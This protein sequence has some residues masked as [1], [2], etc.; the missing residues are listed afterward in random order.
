MISKGR[1]WRGHRLPTSCCTFGWPRGVPRRSVSLCKTRGGLC[2]GSEASLRCETEVCPKGPTLARGRL[3]R[4]WMLRIIPSPFPV[5]LLHCPHPSPPRPPA[6]V[7]L[8]FRDSIHGQIT[9]LS[10]FK[11]RF[12][13]FRADITVPWGYGACLKKADLWVSS[14]EVS[15]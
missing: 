14:S 11:R 13:N 2:L 10:T 9:R 5:H 1:F 15:N 3:W 7:Y 8:L 4:I 6:P 12:S